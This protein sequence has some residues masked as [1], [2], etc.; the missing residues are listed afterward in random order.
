MHVFPLQ[1][2]WKGHTT[3]AHYPR[4]S[5]AST[6]GKPDLDLSSGQGEGADPGAWNPEDL[7]GAALAQ[8]H[9]LTFLALATKVGI[10]VQSYE[11]DVSVVLDTVEKVTSVTTIRL[12][13]TIRVAAGTDPAKVV[14]FFEKAHNYC[15]IANSIKAKV[16][17]S[18]TVI[19][20]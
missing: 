14:K 12:A 20:G 13:P 5:T 9:L 2:S 10:D 3:D 11:D 15:Y 16:E 1:L 17:M 8:C 6:L 18:P 7:L 4:A 19:V